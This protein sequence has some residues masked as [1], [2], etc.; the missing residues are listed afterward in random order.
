M[1]GIDILDEQWLMRDK[2]EE[3]NHFISVVRNVERGKCEMH[4]LLI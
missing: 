3:K 2:I 4:N 1:F